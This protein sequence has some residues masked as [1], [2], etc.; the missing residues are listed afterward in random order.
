MNV[1]LVQ[2]RRRKQACC[3]RETA[4]RSVEH[5]PLNVSQADSHAMTWPWRKRDL[6][7]CRYPA[8]SLVQY[9][10]TQPRSI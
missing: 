3:I 5:G 10:I 8:A 6:S 4:L 1:A 2:C 7:A 9:V